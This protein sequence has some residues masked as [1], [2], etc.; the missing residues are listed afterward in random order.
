MPG[1]GRRTPQAA[2][3]ASVAVA[4]WGRGAAAERPSRSRCC[5]G[6]R[7]ALAAKGGRGPP[8]RVL[9][10]RKQGVR[11]EKFLHEGSSGTWVK[12]PRAGQ[13]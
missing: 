10:S 11:N 2:A 8:R 3:A 5:C 7:I 12:R 13:G 6:C 9:E 4:L 1:A